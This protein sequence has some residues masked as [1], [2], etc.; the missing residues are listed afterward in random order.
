VTVL[1]TDR[2]LL[3]PLTMDDLDALATIYA[4]AEVRRFF[5]EGTL[6]VEETREELEWFIDVYDGRYGFGL[7][8]TIHK[9]SAAFIGRCGLLPWRVIRSEPGRLAL[10]HADEFPDEE[11]AYEVE[12]AYLLAKERW[13]QGLATEAARAIVDDAFGR[14]RLPRLICLVD[15]G[16]GASLKVARNVGLEPDGDVELEGE[17]F[18]LYSISA[19]RARIAGGS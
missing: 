18:P 10:D 5:P 19:E 7:W 8:A 16:N 3:R 9:D 11:A 13:G 2:L 4:D 14:L 1:E 17:V 15:P 6:S 12:L